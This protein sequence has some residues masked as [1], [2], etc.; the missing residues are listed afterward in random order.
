VRIGETLPPA[1]QPLLAHLGIWDRFLAQHHARSFGIRAAWGHDELYDNDFIFN[2]YGAGWHVDRVAFDAM[3]ARCAETAGSRVYRNARPLSC[4][5]SKRRWTIDIG[6]DD[7]RRRFRAR[8]LVDATGR[9]SHAARQQGAKRVSYDALI[10]AFFFLSPGP[11]KS[12]SDDATLIEA[13]E[14]GWWYSAVL[15]DAR[16]VLAYVTDADLYAGVRKQSNDS[17]LGQLAKAK[18]TKSRVDAYVL[19]DDH[20]IVPASSSRL[21]RTATGTWLALGD[22]AMAFDPLSG[23]GVCKALDSAFRAADSID[24]YW[25]GNP[26]ALQQYAVTAE[27]DFDRYLRAR[28]AFYSREQRWPSSPFWR[29]RISDPTPAEHQARS[30]FRS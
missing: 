18:H 8:F 22:A 3:L 7:R 14:E 4:E 28:R 6:C 11:R 24:R 10:G 27:G 26:M 5:Y 19:A 17:C 2:P 23:Q 21:D 9:A 12:G 20:F 16:L 30:P 25:A 15:P 29:R 1:V 13:V